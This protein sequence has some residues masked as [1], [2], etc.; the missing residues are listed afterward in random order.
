MWSRSKIKAAKRFAHIFVK[1]TSNTKT[2]QQVRTLITI[3]ELTNKQAEELK[4]KLSG[5]AYKQL[6][7][8]S[9]CQLKANEWMMT[10]SDVIESFME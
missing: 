2:I 4:G 6:N 5:E 3:F 8:D 1:E 9:V 7:R 10:T